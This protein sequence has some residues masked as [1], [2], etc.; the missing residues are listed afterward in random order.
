MAHCLRGALV[1]LFANSALSAAICMALDGT[2]SAYL[3]R[4]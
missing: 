3:R 4:A 1:W 2:V